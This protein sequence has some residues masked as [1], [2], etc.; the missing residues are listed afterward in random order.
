MAESTPFDA[1]LIDLKVPGMDGISILRAL[2]NRSPDLPVVMITGYGTIDSA[3]EAMKAGAEDYLTKPIN[4]D[5]LE[6]VLG[7]VLE[8]HRRDTETRLLREQVSEMNSFEGLIG[9]S[10][11]MMKVYEDIRKVASID[12]NVLIQGETGTGKEMVAKAIHKRSSRAAEPFV[13]VNCGAF[14][15]SLLESEL[16]GHEK[17]AFTGAIKCRHGF[18]ERASGGTLFLDEI[19]DMSH[20]LQVNLLRVIQEHEVVRVGGEAPISVDFR[21]VAASNQNLRTL[22]DDRAFRSDLYFRLSTVVIDLPPLRERI[23]DIDLTPWNVPSSIVRNWVIRKG[24]SWQ[25]NV[26]PQNRSSVISGRQRFSSPRARPLARLPV[27]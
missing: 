8:S 25:E 14:A 15:E 27:S 20:A 6:I 3:V 17:G 18:A 9:V 26:I 7:K 13:P 1:A 2:K 5:H 19:G 11:Q 21:L 4:L 12:V 10:P 16:Y 23:R 22:M 24:S